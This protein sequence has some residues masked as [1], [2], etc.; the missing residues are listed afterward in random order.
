MSGNCSGTKNPRLRIEQADEPAVLYSFLSEPSA[1]VRRRDAKAIAAL[2]IKDDLPAETAGIRVAQDCRVTLEVV[3]NEPDVN[4]K[5]EAQALLAQIEA[6]YADK[7]RIR[8]RYEQLLKLDQA[9]VFLRKVGDYLLTELTAPQMNDLRTAALDADSALLNFLT[10]CNSGVSEVDRANLAKLYSQ[11][12]VLGQP[13]EWRN[14]DGSQKTLADF[15]GSDAHKI[16]ASIDTATRSAMG[17]AGVDSNLQAEAQA[18]ALDAERAAARVT[19]A[20]IQL[21]GWLQ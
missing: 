4:S 19:Q 10:S 15:L 2:S 16:L 11:L 7:I 5:A 20:K 9:V 17:D 14:T 8:D 12:W 13:D 1:T 6:D 21:A 3:F 18:A